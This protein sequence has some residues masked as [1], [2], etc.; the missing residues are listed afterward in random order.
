ME[1]ASIEGFIVNDISASFI[2]L[3]TNIPIDMPGIYRV[4]KEPGLLPLTTVS[5]GLGSANVPFIATALE[6][7][8]K[9]I[10]QPYNSPG[11]W[12]ADNFQYTPVTTNLTLTSPGA[13][14]VNT[15]KVG[16]ALMLKGA[17]YEGEVG[18]FSALDQ[19]FLG[20][21]MAAPATGVWTLG[22]PS[23][24]PVFAFSQQPYGREFTEGLDVVAGDIIHP[25]PG[26]GYVYE[27]LQTGALGPA[28]SEWHKD[29]SVIC[30]PITLIPKM[31]AA[32]EIH[33]PIVPVPL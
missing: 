28:P 19:E 25:T 21:T 2:S 20:K 14:A 8:V 16:G 7:I 3:A 6:G 24:S 4:Y 31:Y 10:Y 29:R 5:G 23:N 1:F 15:H 22:V 13:S 11:I 33:G 30:G 27:A 26:N 12:Y 32:P 18:V 9:V 17:P